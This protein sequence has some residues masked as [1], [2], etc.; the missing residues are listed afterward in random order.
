MEKP[1]IVFSLVT[2]D[3]GVLIERTFPENLSSVFSMLDS[4]PMD[5]PTTM[6]RPMI[7][8]S[9]QTLTTRA[10]GD[11]TPMS[12]ANTSR[13]RC[14]TGRFRRTGTRFVLPSFHLM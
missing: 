2:A 9:G 11:A 12:R 14:G 5:S 10:W 1:A 7:P 3:V 4:P 8:E 6:L 13:A